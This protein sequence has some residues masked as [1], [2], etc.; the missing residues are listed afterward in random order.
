[1]KVYVVVREGA[2][3]WHPAREAAEQSATMDK[4]AGF[5]VVLIREHGVPDGLSRDKTTE[6]VEE[7]LMAVDF[8]GV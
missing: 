2:F 5:P 6:I 1:M 4:A 7:Q 8:Y 3:E